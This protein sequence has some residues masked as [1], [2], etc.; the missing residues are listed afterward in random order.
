M[1]K[2]HSFPE[3]PSL[4]GG[5]TPGEQ[6]HWV[7]RWQRV[8]SL[9]QYEKLRI[10]VPRTSLSH[11][12]SH[13]ALTFLRKKGRPPER[14]GCYGKERKVCSVLKQGLICGQHSFSH[15]TVYSQLE[16]TSRPNILLC[17]DTR[18]E[19]QICGVNNIPRTVILETLS[20]VKLLSAGDR[21]RN[22]V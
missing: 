15:W 13:D 19:V 9:L 8:H 10:T 18:G 6:F 1:S 14:K 20:C 7:S 21:V 4:R 16:W 5:K 3:D 17:K 22:F 11:T 2:A 12:N